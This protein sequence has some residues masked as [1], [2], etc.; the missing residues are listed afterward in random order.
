M[1]ER[2]QNL[3]EELD[4]IQDCAHFYEPKNNGLDKRFL[5]LL[6]KHVPHCDHIPSG[7][8]H[9]APNPNLSF[10]V[11][12]KN[13]DIEDLNEKLAKIFRRLRNVCPWL[14]SYTYSSSICFVDLEKW[15]VSGGAAS[16]GEFGAKRTAFENFYFVAN[17]FS[18]GVIFVVH[19]GKIIFFGKPLLDLIQANR[20]LWPSFW[21][22]A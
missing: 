13:V 19:G 17:D 14:V 6:Q 20:S 5:K 15:D 7:I 1:S 12:L 4:P 8:Y 22:S 9:N 2:N 21:K 11:S 10:N 16:W 18:F 3:L